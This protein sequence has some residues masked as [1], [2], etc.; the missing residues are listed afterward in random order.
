MILVLFNVHRYRYRYN[1]IIVHFLH[2]LKILLW[3]HKIGVCIHFN[4]KIELSFYFIFRNRETN[5]NVLRDVELFISL[6]SKKKRG[7]HDHFLI[8]FIVRRH[9]LGMGVLHL[10]NHCSHQ[11]RFIMSYEWH[12]GRESTISWR[13]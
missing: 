6:I 13:Q 3:K 8:D 5:P 7:H 1:I 2:F 10:P 9:R 12:R 4:D 11:A